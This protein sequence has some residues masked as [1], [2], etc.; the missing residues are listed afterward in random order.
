M[1]KPRNR[2]NARRPAAAV[3]LLHRRRFVQNLLVVD[4]A[5]LDDVDPRERLAFDPHDGA[6]CCAVVV[7]QVLARVTEARV[8]AVGAGQLFELMGEKWRWLVGWVGLGWGYELTY[9]VARN[10][11]VDAA[12]CS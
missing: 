7:G 6:A 1:R 12:G 8:G 10:E 2:R 3:N 4:G 5:R 11:R 9:L